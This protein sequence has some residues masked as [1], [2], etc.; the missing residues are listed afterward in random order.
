MPRLPALVGDSED[1]DQ[2]GLKVIVEGVGIAPQ[3]DRAGI[4]DD[5]GAEFRQAVEEGERP[6]DLVFKR[7][8]VNCF[9]IGEIPARGFDEFLSG[10]RLEFRLRSLP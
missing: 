5:A 1:A 10:V 4:P 3:W 8:G 7:T 6:R 2:I 9:G